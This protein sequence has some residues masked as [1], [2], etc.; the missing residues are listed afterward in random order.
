MKDEYDEEGIANLIRRLEELVC[1]P[2]EGVGRGDVYHARVHTRF[3]RCVLD[4]MLT[5]CPAGHTRHNQESRI[6]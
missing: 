3:G 4:G 2:T 1:E 6:F 5:I